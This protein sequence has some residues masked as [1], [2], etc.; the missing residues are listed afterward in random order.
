MDLAEGEIA[1][2]RGDYMTAQKYA[3]TATAAFTKP[4]AETY[5]KRALQN[6]KAEIEKHLPQK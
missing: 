6:L 1:L 2:R 4:D 5:Q 3:Q